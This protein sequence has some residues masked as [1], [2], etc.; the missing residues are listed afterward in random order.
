MRL[1]RMGRLYALGSIGPSHTET[2]MPTP[3]TDVRTLELLTLTD[4]PSVTLGL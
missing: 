4:I 2:L 3:V 1:K